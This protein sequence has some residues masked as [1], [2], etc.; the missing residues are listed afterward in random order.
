MYSVDIRKLA[1]SKA[2]FNLSEWAGLPTYKTVDAVAGQL[3][4]SPY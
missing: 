2:V 3:G 1:D 4:A